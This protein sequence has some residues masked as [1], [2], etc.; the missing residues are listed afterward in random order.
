MTS[1]PILIVRCPWLKDFNM[2]EVTTKIKN[3]IAE[4]VPDYH[5]LAFT[6]DNYKDF[7][8]EVVNPSSAISDVDLEMLYK[9]ITE[10]DESAYE[11]LQGA[12]VK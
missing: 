2:A 11:H 1:K 4:Q 5:V 9:L 12:G 8:F 10:E 7:K 3:S 6:K